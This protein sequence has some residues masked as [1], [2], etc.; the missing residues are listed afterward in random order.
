MVGVGKVQHI[1][2]KSCNTAVNKRIYIIFVHA[3]NI[4]VLVHKQLV[5]SCGN[6]LIIHHFIVSEQ[7][8]PPFQ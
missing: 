6:P 5:D 7:K 8:L 4:L 3:G 2:Y 1:N